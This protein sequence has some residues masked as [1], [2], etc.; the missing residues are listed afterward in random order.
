MATVT[1]ILKT[2]PR[3]ILEAEVPDTLIDL[4]LRV[5]QG[6]SRNAAVQVLQ[7]AYSCISFSDGIRIVDGL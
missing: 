5:R 2:T 7:L 4:L 1:V 6:V 3:N